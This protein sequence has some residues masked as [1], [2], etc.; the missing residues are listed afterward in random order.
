MIKFSKETHNFAYSIVNNY[1]QFDPIDKYYYIDTSMVDE[2]DLRSLAVCIMLD[3]KGYASECLS[4]DNPY[5]ER[6]VLD[7]LPFV[8]LD[9]DT[10]L[11]ELII[12]SILKYQEGVIDD[13]L[14]GKV[15]EYNQ[16]KKDAA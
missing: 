7:T 3:D 11:Q 14:Q 9:K 8:L 12:K 16:N 4:I 2:E 5:F 1:A 6:D 15:I 13:L 10:D